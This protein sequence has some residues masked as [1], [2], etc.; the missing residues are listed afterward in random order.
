MPPSGRDI[1]TRVMNDCYSVEVRACDWSRSSISFI[2]SETQGSCSVGEGGSCF[3]LCIKGR[4]VIEEPH[5]ISFRD[6]LVR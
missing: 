2:R 6:L 3:T 4:N 1:R 5:H